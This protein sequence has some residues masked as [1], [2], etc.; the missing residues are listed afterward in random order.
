MDKFKKALWFSLGMLCLGIAYVGLVTPGIPWSTP[1]VA[2]AFCF[3]KS[4]KRWHDYMMNHR[5]FGAF[6]RDWSEYRVFPR[7]GKI[8]MFIT[9]DIS[10]IILWFTTQNLWL[11]LGVAAVMAITCAWA[12]RLP[13]SREQA[14]ARQG[15]PI[16]LK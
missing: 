6:L 9:M 14:I 3:A 15:N 5:I 2:A 12:F 10:L 13:E 4:S 8:L 1:A 7:R 16:D 11:V